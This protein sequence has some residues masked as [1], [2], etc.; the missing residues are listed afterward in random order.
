MTDKRKITKNQLEFLKLVKAGNPDGEGK[1]DLD[2]LLE[3]LSWQPTKAAIHFSIRALVRRDLLKKE[4]ELVL[5]RGR[6][7][8]VFRLGPE[9]EAYFDPRG[10]AS[11][12]FEAVDNSKTAQKSSRNGDP[13]DEI[14]VPS[15]EVDFRE[16]SL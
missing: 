9:G 15:I 11:A 2:Q 14:S 3:R 4:E 12:D 8:V 5:R 1:V 16:L 10:P 6:L 7:R 13:L